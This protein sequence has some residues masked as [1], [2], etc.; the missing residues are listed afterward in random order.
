MSCQAKK[1][2]LNYLNLAKL[3]YFKSFAA[4]S[5]TGFPWIDLLSEEY[6]NSIFFHPLE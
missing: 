6:F 4:Y 5:F 1:L 2:R 3:L